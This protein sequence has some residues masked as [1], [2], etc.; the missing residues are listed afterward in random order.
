MDKQNKPD[1]LLNT[2][3]AVG[4]IS[5]MLIGLV[6]IAVDIFRDNGLLKQLFNKMFASSLGMASIPIAIAVLYFLN[7]WIS[8]SDGKV[9]RGKGNL[10]LY[11]MMAI[12]AFFLFR[13]IATG[14][15]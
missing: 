1:N 11:I 6:G 5:L 4:R 13:L 14:S 9:S 15:F 12:G 7:R 3:A 2:L 8:A 10:P